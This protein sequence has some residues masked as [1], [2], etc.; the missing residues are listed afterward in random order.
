MPIQQF[1]WFMV[2]ISWVQIVYPAVRWCRRKLALFIIL[3]DRMAIVV[4]QFMPLNENC[5]DARGD[6]ETIWKK[7]RKSMNADV[8]IVIDRIE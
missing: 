8:K 5:R 7:E 1:R 4:L 2:K 6:Q 3:S